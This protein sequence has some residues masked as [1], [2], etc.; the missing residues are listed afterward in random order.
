MSHAS[1]LDPVA[2]L[3]GL[4]AKWSPAFTRPGPLVFTS[5]DCVLCGPQQ[6]CRCGEIEFDSPEYHARLDRLHGRARSRPA[7]DGR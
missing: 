7:D 3:D 6:D 1:D 2:T 5:R 4:G